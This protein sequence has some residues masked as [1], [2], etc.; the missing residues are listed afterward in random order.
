MLDKV[1][2]KNLTNSGTHIVSGLAGAAGSGALMAFIPAKHRKVAKVSLAVGAMIVAAASQAG[3]SKLKPTTSALTGI[4]IRQTGEL[5]QEQLK[6]K[7]TITDASP[8]SDKAIAGA[9]GLACPGDCQGSW[10]QPGLPALNS[11]EMYQYDSVYTEIEEE[12]PQLMD[13]A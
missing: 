10:H 1:N 8:A 12:E 2:S 7:Y 4:A 11:P 5:I 3:S 6:N 13:F 9:L